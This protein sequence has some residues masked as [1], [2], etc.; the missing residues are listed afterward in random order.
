IDKLDTEDNFD[1]PD[2]YGIRS[3][4]TLMIFKG[5]EQVDQI[6]GARPKAELKRYLEKALA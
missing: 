3:L 6:F 1:I 5:G 2:R 4:P